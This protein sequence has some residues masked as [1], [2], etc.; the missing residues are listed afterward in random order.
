MVDSVK[1]TGSLQLREVVSND[2]RASRTMPG[3]PAVYVS[4]GPEHDA[5]YTCH[6]LRLDRLAAL[7]SHFPDGRALYRGPNLSFPL[8]W[9][10]HLVTDMASH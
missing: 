3:R 2:A 10:F 9:G 5:A 4:A 6:I 8:G 1:V 7:L